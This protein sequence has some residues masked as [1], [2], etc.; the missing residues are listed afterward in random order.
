MTSD[1]IFILFLFFNYNSRLFKLNLLLP[2]MDGRRG[3]GGLVAGQ[4][5]GG[6]ARN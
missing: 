4:K 5:G 2:P 3:G 1:F 6:E